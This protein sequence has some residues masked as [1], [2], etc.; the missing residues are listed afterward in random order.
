MCILTE[1][2]PIR[3]SLCRLWQQRQVIFSQLKMYLTINSID[4]RGDLVLQIQNRSV[5]FAPIKSTTHWNKIII[6]RHCDSVEVSLTF[7]SL[8]FLR[9][10]I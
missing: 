7:P 5:T 8:T 6:M 9:T 3:I 1:N 2:C 10:N 4:Y